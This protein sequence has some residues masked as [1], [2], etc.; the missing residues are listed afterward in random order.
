[1]EQR[2]EQLEQKVEDLVG[3]IGALTDIIINALGK[4]D[5]NNS[6]FS[7]RFDAINTKLAT[8]SASIDELKGGSDKTI[9]ALDSGFK[10]LK[11]EIQKIN[12][13]TGY[14]D[15]HANT[16]SIRRSLN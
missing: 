6:S 11:T 5:D 12:A 13:V 7:N 15:Q 1:M 4:I 9:G 2:I 14:A 10:D 8:I 16:A 3:H